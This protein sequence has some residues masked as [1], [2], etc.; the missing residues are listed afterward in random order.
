MEPDEKKPRKFDYER[1]DRLVDIFEEC[2]V[3]S[4]ACMTYDDLKKLDDILKDFYRP[5]PPKL[6]RAP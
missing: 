3:G 2:V 5:T 1:Y 6:K 4:T